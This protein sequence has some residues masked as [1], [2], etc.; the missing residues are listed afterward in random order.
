MT[1]SII[2]RHT[3]M[4][5]GA[6][7]PASAEELALKYQ[8]LFQ[9]YSRLKA[10][11]TVL[12][13]AVKKERTENASLQGNVKE[14]EKELRKLQGQLDVLAFHNERLSKRIEAVQEL[15]TKESHF[16]LLGG[17]IKKA[18]EKSTQALDAA[19]T[20][21]AKKIEENE[22][23]H[24]ELSEINHIYTANVK[25]LYAQITTL[26]KRIG[27]LQDERAL[28]HSE[29]SNQSS[30]LVKEKA[31]LEKEIDR[32]QDELSTKA[33]L[34]DEYQQDTS[35][36][37][38]SAA[39]LATITQL[40][41]DLFNQ[42]TTNEQHIKDLEKTIAN[43]N[44]TIQQLSEQQTEV[45]SART[46]KLEQEVAELEATATQLRQE[47]S[48]ASER[49][50]TLEKEIADLQQTNTLLQQAN[51][52]L[53]FEKDALIKNNTSLRI[54]TTGVVD[55]LTKEV[56]DKKQL[57]DD[58]EA[59]IGRLESQ[60]DEQV[61]AGRSVSGLLLSPLYLNQQHQLVALR[62]QVASYEQAS[63]KDSKENGNGSGDDDEEEDDDE[64]FI[65]PVPSAQ[66]DTPT[67][68]T[69]EATGNHATQDDGEALE[70]L[71][72]ER[73]IKLKQYYES[74]MEQLTEELQMADSKA[75]R[76]S[77]MVDTLR[78]KLIKE[79]DEKKTL[80]EKIAQ[81]KDQI[82]KEQELLSTTESSYQ[83]QL[84][85]LTEYTSVLQ[86][87]VNKST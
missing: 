75:E 25:E 7:L 63:T 87:Q 44:A 24:A 8:T 47:T 54:E 13:K 53:A 16:S 83:K 70:T 84:D 41:T 60:L 12:K 56:Q 78:E 85:V 52:T 74:Q 36:E 80:N 20:D 58:M 27:E 32:L 76:F 38:Q 79:E 2:A 15:D 49:A 55:Q 77:S 48:A 73:E 64:P 51:D 1:D 21:L 3:Q 40:K 26:E 71:I 14:K 62:D 69:L 17:T 57:L 28:L 22:E 82:V 65:Y 6:L 35:K 43:L 18:L 67:T 68:T 46:A 34:V 30:V 4:N 29:N 10:K 33:R 81:L 37:E 72:Q 11:H 86:M 9:E 5:A 61:S 39:D 31:D 59:K 19:S 66:D 50:E 23:L 42:S 45:T